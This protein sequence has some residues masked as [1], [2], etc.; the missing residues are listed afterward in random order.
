MIVRS[1]A[2]FALAFLASLA[3]CGE[4][5]A[6]R[7]GTEAVV[8]EEAA[9]AGTAGEPAPDPATPDQPTGPDEGALDADAIAAGPALP[10]E[11]TPY[12]AARRALLAGGYGPSIGEC[13]GIDIATC[14]AF[15]ELDNCS[16]TGAG[17]CDMTF[18]RDGQCIALVTSGGPPEEGNRNVTVAS[19]DMLPGGCDR[20]PL[21]P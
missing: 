21:F 16:G 10:A 6:P 12:N 18:Q 11:G 17:F 1:S 3:A 19:A 15:P 2:I 20:A 9:T 13:N 7:E 4:A 8:V 5:E 14:D